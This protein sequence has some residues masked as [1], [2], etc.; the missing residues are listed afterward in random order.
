[1]HLLN[2]N[3][4]LGNTFGGNVACYGSSV[5][6]S[7]DMEFLTEDVVNLAMMSYQASIEDS[8]F[9]DDS[10][11]VSKYFSLTNDPKSLFESC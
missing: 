6:P 11:L 8:S 5:R 4:N 10:D 3:F 7:L 2:K 1:M 9:F